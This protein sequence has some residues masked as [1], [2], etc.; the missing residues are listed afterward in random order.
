[1]KINSSNTGLFEN[2]KQA[3]IITLISHNL[4]YVKYYFL[5]QIFGNS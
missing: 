4:P 2:I 1:M 5:N 3:P